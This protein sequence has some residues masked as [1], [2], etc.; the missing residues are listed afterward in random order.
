MKKAMIALAALLL[1]AS[2]AMEVEEPYPYRVHFTVASSSGSDFEALWAGD[3]Y[4][5]R[6]SVALSAMDYDLPAEVT[7]DGAGYQVLPSDGGCTLLLLPAGWVV[8]DGGGKI[9]REGP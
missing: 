2:C 1:L 6:G 8:Y 9:I 5:A 3:R 4:Y 7:V